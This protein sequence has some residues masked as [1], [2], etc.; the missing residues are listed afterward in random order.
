MAS[1]IG[2]TSITVNWGA[3][4]GANGYQIY[5]GLRQ[6]KIIG[7]LKLYRIHLLKNGRIITLN[8][9]KIIIMP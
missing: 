3:V 8:Q 6:R 2:E 7:V 4:N 9:E 5:R 1:D